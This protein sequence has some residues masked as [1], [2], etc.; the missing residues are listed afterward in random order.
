LKQLQTI[1]ANTA[2]VNR[3]I[4]FRSCRKNLV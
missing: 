4:K 2:T 1:E 3:C